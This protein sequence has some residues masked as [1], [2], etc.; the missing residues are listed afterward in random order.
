VDP[1]GLIDEGALGIAAA[2]RTGECSATAIVEW[3]LERIGRLNPELGA[4][5]TT[6]AVGALA[7]A[8]TLDTARSAGRACGPLHG[9]P[10]AYKDLC[11]IR[12]LPTGCG[13]A[14]PEYFHAPADCVVAR[15]LTRAGAITLG[16]LAMTELAMGSFGLNDVQGTPRNPLALDR[17]PGGSSSG[18]GVALAAGLVAG[19]V[20]SDTGGSIRIPAACCGVVGLKPTYGRIGRS[21]I[22]PLSRSLDHVGPM[23]RRVGDVALMLS[24]MAGYDRHDPGSAHRPVA[25][26]P[27]AVDVR[28]L[29]VGVA[30]DDYF[31]D[32]TDEV[33]TTVERTAEGLRALGVVV[34]PLAL[35]DPTPIVQATATIVRAES[36]AEH[37]HRLRDSG[38][39]LQPLLRDRLEEGLRITAA[40]YLHALEAVLTFRRR[41]LRDVFSRVDLVLT[42]TLPERPLL[43]NEARAGGA[44]R[45]A[46]FAKFARLFNGLGIPVLAL[47]GG[48]ATDGTPLGVQFAARDFDEARLLAVGVAYER[49]TIHER[50]KPS[51]S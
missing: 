45:M 26:S 34:Q 9:V 42:P 23:G 4:F 22:M 41:F 32:V 19:A 1:G 11:F 50:R 38:T 49:S 25:H 33:A 14:M 43:L 17:I 48:Q 18:C 37:G 30:A 44:A 10:V 21:G 20:G 46:H 2:V 7:R 36:A 35:P 28:G 29:R 3:L 12:G 31:R 15:R 51:P 40:D 27:G 8:K 5:V 39:A 16:K 47:P 24:V 13:T 6:D